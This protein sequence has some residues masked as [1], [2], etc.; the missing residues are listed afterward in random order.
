MKKTA[1]LFAAL[2][3]V[4]LFASGPAFAQEE[5]TRD[6][7]AEAPW[8]A[9]AGIGT[10]H[11]EGDEPVNDGVVLSLRAGHDFNTWF[12][13]EVGIIYSPQLDNSEFDNPE[14]MSP[15]VTFLYS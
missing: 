15:G 12:S 13:T 5:S 2:S 4:V 9:S 3:A 1:R 10:I 6:L 11:Y 8:Y 7:F 14:R